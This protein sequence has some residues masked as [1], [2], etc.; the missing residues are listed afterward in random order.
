LLNLAGYALEG[1]LGTYVSGTGSHELVDFEILRLA[2]M[3]HWS[4]EQVSRFESIMKYLQ[5]EWAVD[6]VIAE[7]GTELL[8]ELQYWPVANHHDV[9]HA[10]TKQDLLRCD[11]HQLV[12]ISSAERHAV[13]K[14]IE[15]VCWF[16]GD[17]H[18]LTTYPTQEQIEVALNAHASRDMYMYTH[19]CTK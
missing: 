11:D 17:D 10:V 5:Q 3:R 18:P 2:S 9:V 8:T 6:T 7:L 14:V 16:A 1:I 4:S 12:D 13:V 19:V 15:L